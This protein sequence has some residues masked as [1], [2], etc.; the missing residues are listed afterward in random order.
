MISE[1]STTAQHDTATGKSPAPN[2]AATTP[3]MR[4]ITPAIGFPAASTIAGKVMTAS[5]TYGT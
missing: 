5:V 4:A 3:T 2:H 1:M